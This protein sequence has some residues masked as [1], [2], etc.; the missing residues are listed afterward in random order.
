MYK[1]N[2]LVAYEGERSNIL[3]F[4]ILALD[5]QYKRGQLLALTA[6]R[7]RMVSERSLCLAPDSASAWWNTESLF[8]LYSKLTHALLFKHT[9]TSTF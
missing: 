2:G 1:N 7:L 5:I 3:A 8:L 9:F 6:Y 4:L